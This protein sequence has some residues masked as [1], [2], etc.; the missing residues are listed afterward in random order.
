MQAQCKSLE[1]ALISVFDQIEEL[2]EPI[3]LDA[4]KPTLELAKYYTP[5]DTG[6]L[7]DSGYLEGTSTKSYPRVEIGFGF[8]GNPRYT[9]YVHEMVQIAHA[10]P[11]QAKFLQRAVLE[12]L[13]NIYDRLV[14]GYQEAF[15]GK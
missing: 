4:M 5:V 8:G 2:S 11:T 12:D 9:V 1:E 6:A 3:M 14:A 7:V 13:P 15:G 10:A